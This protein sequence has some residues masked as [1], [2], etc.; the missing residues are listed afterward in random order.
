MGLIFYGLTQTWRRL[1]FFTVF[2]RFQ[3]LSV[4]FLWFLV[5]CLCGL[6]LL[7]R[8]VYFRPLIYVVLPFVYIS[9]LLSFSVIFFTNDTIFTIFSITHSTC[10]TLWMTLKFKCKPQPPWGCLS[11]L[12]LL[13]C[14]RVLFLTFSRLLVLLLLP[15]PTNQVRCLSINHFFPSSVRW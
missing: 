12:L 1:R 6:L 13:V 10:G 8:L 11:L 4:S 14:L 7:R 2:R 5:F 9:V 3:D 15:H